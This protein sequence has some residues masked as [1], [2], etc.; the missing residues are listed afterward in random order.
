MLHHTMS[1][2]ALN[3]VVALQDSGGSSGGGNGPDQGVIAALLAAGV[4]FAC[5]G[6][7]VYFG[8]KALFCWLVWDAQR[9]VPANLR[10][11]SPGLVWLMMI[12]LF[13]L[14]WGFF[15]FSKVP[16]SLQAAI[17]E[18]GMTAEGDCGQRWGLVFAILHAC[19]L[20]AGFLPFVGP[21]VGVAAIVF[22]IMS[23]VGIRT[24]AGR[25]VR[26]S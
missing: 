5:C 16:L 12:P 14:V 18:R 19:S 25:L 11:M 24:A 26:G 6:L 7:A 10:L 1:T 2:L 17:K 21:L 20:V 23:V 13:N 4:A 9:K 22:L 15:V 8:I 3:A